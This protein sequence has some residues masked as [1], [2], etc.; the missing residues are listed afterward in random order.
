MYLQT[1]WK[2]FYLFIKVIRWTLFKGHVSS[3][4]VLD[5]T[6]IIGVDCFFSLQIWVKYHSFKL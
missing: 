3:Q 1:C 4:I 6:I 2:F 5:Q